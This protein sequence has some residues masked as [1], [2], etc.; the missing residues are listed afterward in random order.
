MDTNTSKLQ[1]VVEWPDP[2]D[3]VPDWV[4]KE[5]RDTWS[6][7]RSVGSQMEAFRLFERMTDRLGYGRRG[8]NPSLVKRHE[9][10]YAGQPDCPPELK[11]GGELHTLKCKVCGQE[12]PRSSVC[13]GVVK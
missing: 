3:T 11:A 6:A 7:A 9:Y 10:W 5:I 2:P 8:N 13:S 4:A 12:N 1:R